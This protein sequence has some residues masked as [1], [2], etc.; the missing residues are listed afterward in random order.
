MKVT[1]SPGRASTG[2]GEA[3]MANEFEQPPESRGSPAAVA[4][5]VFAVLFAVGWVLLRQRPPLSATDQE[6]IDYFSDPGSRRASLIAGLYV[7]P[8]AGIAFVRLMAALRAR[9]VGTRGRENTLRPP[10][11]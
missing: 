1:A 2:E 4:G 7:V 6:L 3:L 10:S 11:T 9:Y 5:L 8:F